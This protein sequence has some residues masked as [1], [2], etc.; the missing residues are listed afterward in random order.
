MCFQKEK[1]ITFLPMEVHNQ[2]GYKIDGQSFKKK[3]H[4][5]IKRKELEFV[6]Q[7]FV[8]LFFK[9]VL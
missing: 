5:L 3:E 4:T 1:K 2:M 7:C 6:W 9:I 8:L